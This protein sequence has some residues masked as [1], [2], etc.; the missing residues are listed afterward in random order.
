[1][2]PDQ[3]R[4][5]PNFLQLPADDLRVWWPVVLAAGVAIALNFIPSNNVSR[6]IVILLGCRYLVWRGWVTLNDAHWLSCGLVNLSRTIGL[7]QAAIAN[8][9]QH[10]C[11][12]P[13]GHLKGNENIQP[14]NPTATE[15][16]AKLTRRQGHSYQ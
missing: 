16:R 1:M 12:R 5:L 6:L 2:N 7:K 10:C 9:R 4:P 15:E 3:L 13:Q 8:K 14:R 11:P